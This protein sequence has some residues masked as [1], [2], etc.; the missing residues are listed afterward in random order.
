VKEVS[1]HFGHVF[2]QLENSSD[3]FEGM[4]EFKRDYCKELSMLADF[5][6]MH[7]RDG[8][9]I[10][11]IPFQ[12]M[13]QSILTDRPERLLRC[14]ASGNSLIYIDTNGMCYVCDKL[15]GKDEFSIGNIKNGISQTPR[16]I[17]TELNSQCRICNERFLCG[18]RCLAQLLYY[19]KRKFDF[20]CET[21]RM[22]IDTVKKLIPEIKIL[23]EEKIINEEAISNPIEE[24]TEQIP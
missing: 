12:S 2:W 21:T 7:L 4:D 18:G 23:L 1:N 8:N 10:N 16:F 15:I 22:L 19:P 24:C 6:M 20:Y 17:H 13:A 9:V 11:L 14:G 5:W 3:Q